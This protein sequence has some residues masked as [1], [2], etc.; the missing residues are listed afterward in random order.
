MVVGIIST[1]N[2]VCPNDVDDGIPV[3]IDE[4]CWKYDEKS[5]KDV[6]S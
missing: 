5:N 2:N 1:T 6:S 3:V 4:K